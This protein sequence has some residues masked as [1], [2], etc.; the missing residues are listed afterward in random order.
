[1]NPHDYSRIM[2]AARA[3]AQEL[4]REAIA[5]FWSAVFSGV[6]RLAATRL[7]LPRAPRLTATEA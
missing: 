2:D 6:R 4:R 1:M 7:R 5:D 3:R